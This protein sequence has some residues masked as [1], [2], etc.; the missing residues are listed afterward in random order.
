MNSFKHTTG[1]WVAPLNHEGSKGRAVWTADGSTMICLCQSAGTSLGGEQAN[2][3]LCAAAPELLEA[4]E[5]VRP[6]LV[7]DALTIVISAISK[8]T[9][10]DH[11]C[12]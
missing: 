11:G 3:T 9:G 10:D 1:P 2:A 12:L 7:G 4:W 5:K 8:A 6:C